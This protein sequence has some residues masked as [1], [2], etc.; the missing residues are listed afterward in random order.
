MK[1]EIRKDGTLV[2]IA[3]TVVEAWAINGVHPPAAFDCEKCGSIPH[4][5]VFDCSILLDTNNA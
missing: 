5:V 3:E 2:I 4:K 1:V